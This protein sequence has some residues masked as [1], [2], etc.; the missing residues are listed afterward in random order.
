MSA[1]G[2]RGGGAN[3]QRNSFLIPVY[4]LGRPIFL[5]ISSMPSHNNHHEVCF[6]HNETDTYRYR[7]FNAEHGSGGS[8]R[9]MLEVCDY[10]SWLELL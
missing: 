2:R 10:L 4:A 6:R 7:N 3:K 9:N 8:C 5:D 1:T